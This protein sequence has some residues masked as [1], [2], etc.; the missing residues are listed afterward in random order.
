[1]TAVDGTA[2]AHAARAVGAS[3]VL[4][5]LVWALV[6]HHGVGPVP[7]GGAQQWWEPRGFLLDLLSATSLGE[8]LDG[9]ARSFGAGIAPA[10]ALVV[11]VFA[12]TRSAVGRTLSVAAMLACALFL[13]YGL[14]ERARIWEF[15]RW[16]GSAV[17]TAL[18]LVIAAA[19]CA[20]LLAA[21][22]LR[23]GR[24]ARAAG[25]VPVV[26]LV[27]VALRDVTGTDPSLPFAISPWPVVTVFGM[28]LAGSVIAAV[29]ALLA[30][31]LALAARF[32]TR[33]LLGAALVALLLFGVGVAVRGGARP[34]PGAEILIVALA[35]GAIALAVTGLAERTAASERPRPLLRGARASAVGTLLVALPLFLGVRVVERDYVQTRDRAAQKVIDALAHWLEREGTYP[36]SL[37]EL[38][39]AKDLDAVPVPSIGFGVAE[40][41]TFT[42]QSFGT[43]YILEFSAPRWV[44]CAYNPPYEDADAEEASAA[45]GGPSPD[46]APDGAADPRADDAGEQEALASGAWSCPSKP[47]ELW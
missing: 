45:E 1:M 22:W 23:L 4:A 14:G 24:A 41:Q 43:S 40:S 12:S 28:E 47:P 26:G 19:L 38:V 33:P 18:A 36:D 42:Y 29:L 5:S 9:P 25:Y 7:Q 30:L 15:F 35:L 37:E 3:L 44:Q 6:I 27:I 46:E 20:P 10:I 2:R 32:A 39:Q 34:Q 13:F 31:A 8:L 11:A 17:M 21:S 16:R